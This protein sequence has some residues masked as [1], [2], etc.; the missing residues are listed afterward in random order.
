MSN[1]FEDAG[2]VDVHI[3][4]INNTSADLASNMDTCQVGIETDTG[5]LAHKDQSDN[6]HTSAPKS[7]LTLG[8]IPKCK[9]A[10]T[11]EL[12]NASAADI[13][14]SHTHS[15]VVSSN[16]SVN[17][18]YACDTAGNLIGTV[19]TDVTAEN[20]GSFQTVGGL[21]VK[22]TCWVKGLIRA[23][24]AKFG[25][26]LGGNYSEFESTGTLKYN[27]GAVVWNDINIS[28]D[29]LASVGASIL[30]VITVDSNKFRAFI[31]TGATAQ[32]ADGSL[33]ILHD[34]KEG[35]DITPHLHWMPETAD[36]GD[37]KVSLGYRWWDGGGV[38]PAETVI[39]F[40]VSASGSA[41]QETRSNFGT[42]SGI[43]KHIGSRFVFR[44]FRDPADVADT[45]THYVIPLDF[46][47]HYVTDTTGSRG[48]TSK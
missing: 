24:T 15:K 10:A 48:T 34:Y 38:M 36:A 29:S 17:P 3:T 47:L 2:A 16:G 22:L 30:D 9:V 31:G 8:S 42:I 46:G 4:A 19:A 20:T 23:A 39:S 41:L 21:Y 25:D 11:G 37:V 33:E 43:G 18:A 6:Y 14:A 13:E 12:E 1:V 40:T 26:I 5:L 32:Q 44:I 45:Y 35:S 7:T 28:V 27:G